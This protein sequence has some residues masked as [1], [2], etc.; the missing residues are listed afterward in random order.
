MYVQE[1]GKTCINISCFIKHA[2]SLTSERSYKCMD[3]ENPSTAIVTSLCIKKK[4]TGA[5]GWLSW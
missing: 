2:R 3:V 4:I 1:C 5:P